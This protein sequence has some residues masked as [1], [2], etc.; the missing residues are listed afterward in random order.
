MSQDTEKKKEKKHASTL[1][2]AHTTS[3]HRYLAEISNYPVLSREEEFNLAKKYRDEGDLDAARKLVTSNLKF[4]VRVANEYK[5]YGFSTMDIIQEGN[6]GLMHAVKGFDPTKGYRLISYAVWWI[7]AYIQNY[8]I[9][10]W[11]LVKV[12]TTQAQR[13]LFYKLRSTKKELEMGGE[14]LS[15]E[16]YRELAERLD[17]PDEAVIEMEQRMG[18]KDLSLDAELTSE[19]DASHLDFLTG[20]DANQEELL[21]KAQ[22]EET[23]RKG[24]AVALKT[25]KDR[26]RYIIEKRVLSDQPLTLEELGTKFNISRERVRQIESAALK[27]IKDVLEEKGISK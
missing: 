7:R 27:K 12:G 17:V 22:E 13:K 5:N 6:V 18:S 16:D 26:E 19:K 15:T 14:A 9:K 24:M 3:L 1:L 21:T 8:I 11:S 20:G 4:V 10:S 2:P 25:L 23:V